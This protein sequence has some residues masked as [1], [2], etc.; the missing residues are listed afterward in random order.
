MRCINNT[1]VRNELQGTA[2]SPEEAWCW[3]FSWNMNVGEDSGCWGLGVW[4][5]LPRCLVWTLPIP[6]GWSC[7]TQGRWSCRATGRLQ[8][9][10]DFCGKQ[11]GVGIL[12][13]P[14]WSQLIFLCF[15]FNSERLIRRKTGRCTVLC[16][17]RMVKGGLL[18][19]TGL[20]LPSVL[21]APMWEKNLK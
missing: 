2:R 1:E 5:Q 20:S 8:D 9:H 3:Q 7:V 21:G 16:M 4:E 18:C 11:A 10:L 17:E 13:P 14:V 15:R 12:A 19:S 6:S